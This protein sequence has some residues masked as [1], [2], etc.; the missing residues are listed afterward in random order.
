METITIKHDRIRNGIFP[1]KCLINIE[2]VYVSVSK[3]E[4]IYEEIYSIQIDTSIHKDNIQDIS[5][6]LGMMVQSFIMTELYLKY[7]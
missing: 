7:R 2:G 1:V 4:K 3:G 6:Q 5:F